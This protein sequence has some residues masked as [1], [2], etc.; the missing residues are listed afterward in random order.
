MI[1]IYIYNM[2][3]SAVLNSIRVQKIRKGPPT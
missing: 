2:K 1:Y 3:A